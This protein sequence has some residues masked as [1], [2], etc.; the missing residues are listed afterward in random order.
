M[1]KR[2]F[3]ET[4]E[5]NLLFCCKHLS[6]ISYMTL[7]K[8]KSKPKFCHCYVLNY[9]PMPV[10]KSYSKQEIDLFLEVKSKTNK[11]VDKATTIVYPEKNISK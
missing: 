4:K 11:Y 9:L 5:V 2:F 10:E 7:Y 1:T 6:T 3:Y 8:Q